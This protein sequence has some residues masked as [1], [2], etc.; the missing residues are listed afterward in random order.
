MAERIERI[1]ALLKLR[2]FMQDQGDT[3]SK[4]QN[5]DQVRCEDMNG[6]KVAEEDAVSTPKPCQMDL[7]STIETGEV[8]SEL[9]S[10]PSSTP[11][12]LSARG[13]VEMWLDSVPLGVFGKVCTDEGL[14]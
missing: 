1:E 3:A 13:R 10:K 12:K 11:T 6:D 5:G 2:G 7:G 4:I 9:D 8:S 14:G